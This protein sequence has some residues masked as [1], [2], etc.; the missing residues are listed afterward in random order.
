MQ[1]PDPPRRKPTDTLLP[2]IN[3][4]FLL[5]IFFLISSRFVPPEPF[6]VTP[7]E[8][9]GQGLG[10][11]RL[12]LLV[13]AEGVAGYGGATG[14]AALLALA[15]SCGGACGV[16]LLRAD[17]AMPAQRLAALL[18]RLAALGFADIR[19]LTVPR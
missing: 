2:M 11:G 10:D 19:L 4:V 1:F 7:P 14:E 16:L 3:V 6:P 5:V 8:A 13:N 12:T 15:E 17:A 18:P 9:G